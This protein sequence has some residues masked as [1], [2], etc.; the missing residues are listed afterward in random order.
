MRAALALRAGGGVATVAFGTAEERIV[1]VVSG[2]SREPAQ[3]DESAPWPRVG[4]RQ[5]WP[6]PHFIG[7]AIEPGPS[8]FVL[9]PVP[10]AGNGHG[11]LGDRG[12]SIQ[13]L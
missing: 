8:W 7:A 13:D 5:R 11:R 4:P 2:C 1:P 6:P 3:G 9:D 10:K 12:G